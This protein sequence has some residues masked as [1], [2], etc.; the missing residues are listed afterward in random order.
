MLALDYSDT[1]NEIVTIGGV[2]QP[3]VKFL[4]EAVSTFLKV[5]KDYALCQDR[6]AIV[7]FDCHASSSGPLVQILPGNNI[8]N[9]IAAVESRAASGCTAMGAGLATGLGIL[10]AGPNKRFVVLFTDGMQNRNPL[11]YHPQPA[12]LNIDQAASANYPPPLTW[13]CSCASGDGGKSN[14]AGPLPVVLNGITVPIYTI[15]IGV[16]GPWQQMLQDISSVTVPAGQFNADVQVWP[17]L[18]EFFIETLIDLFRGNS[19]QLVAKSQ[20]T[21]SAREAFANRN[22]YVEQ[23]GQEIDRPPEL[24]GQPSAVDLQAPK[25][26]DRDKPRP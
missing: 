12:S 21:L 10:G 7:Y 5:W 26:R 19:L 17:Q 13:L 8:Q 23:V 16:P 2:T 11:V 4:Q 6:I 9:L 25:R 15:G 20:G 24:G 3:K 22:V 18:K 14:Y 1:M